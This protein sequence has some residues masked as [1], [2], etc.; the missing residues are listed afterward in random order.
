MNYP[1]LRRANIYGRKDANEQWEIDNEK[2][3]SNKNN[4]NSQTNAIKKVIN[5]AREKG[6][7]RIIVK[8]KL[9]DIES[10]DD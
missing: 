4:A 8:G 3:L 9:I 2:A 1:K 6:I 7:K 10:E 5:Q